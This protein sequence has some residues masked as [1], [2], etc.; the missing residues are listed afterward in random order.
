VPGWIQSGAQCR[1]TSAT[2]A[3][4]RGFGSLGGFYEAAAELM[5]GAFVEEISESEI[6]LT[7]K[8]PE[9]ETRSSLEEKDAETIVREIN[10]I[11]QRLDSAVDTGV[12][13]DIVSNGAQT[14]SVNVVEAGAK[15]KLAPPEFMKIFDDFRGVHMTLAE[16]DAREK[17]WNY[18]VIIYAK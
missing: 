10:T 18:E 5:P 4:R 14:E 6:R 9:L 17:T 3:F 7:A 8:L 13:V 12:E 16:W 15:S 11:F 1:E 2:V